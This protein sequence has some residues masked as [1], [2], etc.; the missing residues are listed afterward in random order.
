MKNTIL[1]ALI[2]CLWLLSMTPAS[3]T[4][5][6]VVVSIKPLHSLVSG[7]M[8]GIGRPELLVESGGSPHGYSLKPSEAKALAAAD[9]IIWVGQD[10]ESFLVKPLSTLGKEAQQLRLAEALKSDLLTRRQGGTWEAPEHK[11]QEDHQD[12]SHS[13]RLTTATADLHL[14]LSPPLAK[15]IVALSAAKLSQLDPVNTA[16]Y[17]RNSE[18]LQ[19]RLEVLDSALE[20]RLEPVKNVPYIVFHAAYQYFEST[21]GLN[22][23]GSVTINPER[24]PGAKR[25]KAI[26][27]KIRALDARCVF[28]E[29]QFESRLIQTIISE[30]DARTGT[31]DPLGADIAAGPEAYFTLMNRLADN[32]IEGLR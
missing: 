24:K 13:Q 22:A 10:L 21:Y 3:A 15:K 19:A 9:L 29:P 5:P 12:H 23:V 31:L 4:P 27:Q 1:S 32:L 30:T 17:N 26:Q 20:E 2:L 8:E 25:L 16:I 18:Q 28:S 11:H 6:Q 14:W 7:V